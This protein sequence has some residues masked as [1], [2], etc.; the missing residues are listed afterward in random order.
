MAKNDAKAAAAAT[1]SEVA[2]AGDRK[3]PAAA[4][5]A[6]APKVTAELLKQAGDDNII[7]VTAAD[8][9]RWRA[10]REFGREATPLR[11][12]DVSAA[13]L[14]AILD[15]PRLNWSPAPPEAAK[16]KS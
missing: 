9:R 12:G 16:A 13:D 11:L 14:Q 5:P 1:D 7:L 10:G 3:S 4:A 2:S 15:D 8:P 6:A